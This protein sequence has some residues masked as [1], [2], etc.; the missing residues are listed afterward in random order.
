MRT[1]TVRLGGWLQRLAAAIGIAFLLASFTPVDRWWATALAGPWDDPSGDVLIVLTGSGLED[2]VIGL[3]SYWR[4]VYALRFYRQE[5]FQEVLISGAAPDVVM[6]ADM[7]DFLAAEGLPK[8]AI[9]IE[10]ESHSTQQSAV[11]VARL[12]GA[13]P[14]RYQ[15]RRLVLLTSDY[16]MFRSHRAFTKV[17][18]SVAPR[19]IP[20]A[21]KRYNSIQERWGIFLELTLETAK[22]GYY[23]A[24]GWI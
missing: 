21:R 5:G 10:T 1:W 3:S 19:P 23:W 8:E 20:D 15:G 16:H 6:A 17:G 4:A 12:V 18:L 22:I 7:R 13:E 24:H 14:E 2:G 9:R 11:N